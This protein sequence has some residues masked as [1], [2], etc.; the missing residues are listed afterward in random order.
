MM[1]VVKKRLST[2]Y[3]ILLLILLVGIDL[4][5]K[6]IAQHTKCE[7]NFVAG[8]GLKYVENK[9][10]AF[11]WL[12]QT[13]Y[14]VLIGLIITIILLFILCIAYFWYIS[15]RNYIP[16][17]AVFAFVLIL[18]GNIGVIIDR[19]MFNCARDFIVIP[20]FAIINFTEIYDNIGFILVFILIFKEL[21]LRQKFLQFKSE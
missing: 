1:K 5:T 6:T 21:K 7:I 11:G 17:I 15:K 4:A 16:W 2:K 14:G 9:G 18:S 8:F 10:L 20:K 3:I 12:S 19:A 13:G